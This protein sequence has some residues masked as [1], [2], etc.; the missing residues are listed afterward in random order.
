METT[1]NLSHT[2]HSSFLHCWKVERRE[3]AAT[4][5]SKIKS[6]AM[7]PA[8]PG[9]QQDVCMAESASVSS[10][11]TGGRLGVLFS[12]ATKACPGNKTDSLLKTGVQNYSQV[13]I[14]EKVQP[15]LLLAC[16]KAQ[17]EQNQPFFPL[18]IQLFLYL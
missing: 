13:F 18:W 14:P 6:P 1:P 9:C 16:L 2:A 10:K 7:F 8:V 17:K 12:I 11:V 15:C 3:I 4:A 5:V